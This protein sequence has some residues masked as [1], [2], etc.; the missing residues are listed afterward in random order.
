MARMTQEITL[1]IVD[2]HPVFRRGLREVI[3]ENRRFK[4]VGEAPDGE[5]ALRQVAACEPRI[6]LVDI[7]MPHLN[8]LEMV[9]ALR[10]MERPVDIVFLTMYREEDMF[11]AAM[12]LGVKAYVLKENASDDI[13]AAIEKVAQGG[14]FISPS[15]SDMGQRR[16]ERVRQLLLG[17]PQIDELTSAERRILKLIAEDYTSKQIADLLQISAKTVENHRLNICHKLNLHG[18]HSLLKF[19]FDHKSYI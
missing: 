15:M 12:D 13:L 2:D 17:K 4:I 9:R 18:S 7:D 8:G 14:T 6:A 5:A 19:A 3:E 11:N 10:K 1:L 16:S